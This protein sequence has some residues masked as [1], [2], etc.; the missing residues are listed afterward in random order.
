RLGQGRERARE[1]LKENPEMAVE[2]E[3]KLLEKMLPKP[4]AAA[5]ETK[6]DAAPAANA[7]KA[8]GAS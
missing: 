7:A 2:I 1:F 5:P 8:A 3:E 6:G 4:A